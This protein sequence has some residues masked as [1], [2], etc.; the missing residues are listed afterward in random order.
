MDGITFEDLYFHFGLPGYH[1]SPQII[2]VLHGEKIFQY[3]SPK[4]ITIFLMIFL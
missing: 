4:I 1:A 2:K 3:Y